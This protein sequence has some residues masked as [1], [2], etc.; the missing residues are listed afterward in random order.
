MGLEVCR[1]I[2]E[3]TVAALAYGLD[4]TDSSVIAVYANPSA[5]SLHSLANAIDSA[6]VETQACERS[7]R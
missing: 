1:V 2:N 7:A 5:V 4:H 3:P 6:P